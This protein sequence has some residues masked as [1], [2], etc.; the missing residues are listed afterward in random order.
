M[1]VSRS[2]P[3]FSSF[4]SARSSSSL[5]SGDAMARLRFCLPLVAGTFMQF[6]IAACYLG[7][8]QVW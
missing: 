5:H 1:M 8:Y 2:T 4:S 3:F 6:R 7:C